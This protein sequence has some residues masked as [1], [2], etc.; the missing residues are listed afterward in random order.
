LIKSKHRAIDR[1][2]PSWGEM[3][4]IGRLELPRICPVTDNGRI[5][6]RA[7]TPEDKCPV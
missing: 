4:N 1:C 2:L 5:A 7:S 3:A 6:A